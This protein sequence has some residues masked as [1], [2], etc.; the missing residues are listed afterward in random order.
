M[1]N[2]YEYANEIIEAH[3]ETKGEIDTLLGMCRAVEADY[4]RIGKLT[5][6][7]D[8]SPVNRM[9]CKMNTMLRDIELKAEKSKHQDWY[10]FAPQRSIQKRG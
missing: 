9:A 2:E 8:A 3:P 10:S 1:N 4:Q 7:W 5:D 6:R